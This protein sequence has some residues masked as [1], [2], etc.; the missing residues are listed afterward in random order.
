MEEREV[1]VVITENLQLSL[2]AIT[3]EGEAEELMKVKLSGKTGRSADIILID[4]SLIV[5]ALGETVIRFW[6]LDRDENYVLSPD[7]QFGFEG[8][9]CINCVSYCSAKGLLAA[10]TNKGR[11]AMWRKAAGSDQ[12]TRA[13]E[14]K[15]WKLQA[16]TEL[17]GSV[18]QI[19]VR[20]EGVFFTSIK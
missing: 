7:V 11:I 6:D 9:E 1:L 2:H 3:P 10:G 12:G 15:K 5:T 20:Q 19:K 13:S 14:A 18:I 17:E 8:G 16:P 4:H